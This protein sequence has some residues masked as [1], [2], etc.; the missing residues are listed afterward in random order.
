MNSI[1]NRMDIV[2][3]WISPSGLQIVDPSLELFANDILAGEAT[4]NTLQIKPDTFQELND[5]NYP[6]DLKCTP[7][8]RGFQRVIVDEYYETV[9][10]ILIRDDAMTPE[11]WFLGPVPG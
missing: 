9:D 7:A 10:R 1:A 11:Q 5:P 2:N 3:F 6:I 8:G 4:N